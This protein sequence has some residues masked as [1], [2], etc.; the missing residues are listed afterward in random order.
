MALRDDFRSNG[1][2][3]VRKA[4]VSR[5]GKLWWNNSAAMEDTLAAGSPSTQYDLPLN[6]LHGWYG[7]TGKEQLNPI[8]PMHLIVHLSGGAIKSKFADDML[9]PQGLSAV[10]D[11]LF[12]PPE[13]MQKCALW[14]GVSSQECYES[15][16]G[17]QGALVVIDE[18]NENIF[19]TAMKSHGIEVRRAGMIT[20]QRDYAVALVPRFGHGSE[21]GQ[22][23]YY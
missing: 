9:R 12:E 13:I 14:Q 4:F 2:S 20:E 22:K 23:V 19:T 3:L 21:S 6:K 17:G 18:Y 15:W 7:L 16:N 10:L 1:F 8:I 5:Y 11:N